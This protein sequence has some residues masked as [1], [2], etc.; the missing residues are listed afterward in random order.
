MHTHF[1]G[2][3]L[4]LYLNL[5]VRSHNLPVRSPIIQSEELRQLCEKTVI[6]LK[7]FGVRWIKIQDKISKIQDEGS[8][9]ADM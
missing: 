3:K 2:W 5:P 9:M 6:D 1:E 7:G 4:S 8:N